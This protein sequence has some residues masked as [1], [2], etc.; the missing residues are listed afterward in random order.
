VRRICNPQAGGSSPPAGSFILDEI[1]VPA[2]YRIGAQCSTP[3]GSLIIDAISV[4]ARYRIGAQSQ[5]PQV[6]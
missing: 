1:S 6:L 3:A 4:P 5:P 2:R